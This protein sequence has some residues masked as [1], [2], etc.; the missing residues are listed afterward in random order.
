MGSA[1]CSQIISRLNLEGHPEGGYYVQTLR[2]DSIVLSKCPWPSRE[3]RPNY[4]HCF[5]TILFGVGGEGLS[6]KVGRPVST[7]VYSL[8]P[9]GSV[10]RLHWLP[11]AE[12]LH[13]YLGEPLTVFELYE[14][15]NFKLTCVGSDLLREEHQPQYTIPPYVWFSLFP[16]NVYTISTDGALKVNKAEPRDAEKHYSRLGATCAPAFRIED[17]E[18]AKWAEFVSRFPKLEPLISL[19]CPTNG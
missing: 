8:L 9:S 10:T 12:T 15:G 16:T 3:E 6:N 13:F 4:Q 5:P 14:D 18:V 11:C 17:A 7:S 2:D 1:T 19:P